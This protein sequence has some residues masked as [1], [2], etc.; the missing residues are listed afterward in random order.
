MPNLKYLFGAY[1]AMP[2]LPVMYLQGKRVKE[3]VPKLPEALGASGTVE[4]QLP[5]FR[6]VTIGESTIAGV[7]VETH[8]EGFTGTLAKR[9]AA[10]LNT[11]LEWKV[12]AKSGYTVKAMRHKLVPKVEEAHIDLIVIGAGAND[13]F[14]LSS[15]WK[16][17]K[18]VNALITELRKK[19]GHTP[20]VFTNMPPIKSFPAFTPLMKFFLG[21][22][23]D[24]LGEVLA[25]EV[26]KHDN[27][28]FYNRKITLEDWIERLDI[29][30]APEDFFSDGVHPSK[31]TYQTW[32]KDLVTFMTDNQMLRHVLEQKAKS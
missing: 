30:A 22:L 1:L 27:V 12:Y 5:F 21:N 8:E 4:G 29:T 25:A 19:Y 11:A 31:L 28:F 9:L 23:V 13:A 18:D 15:P 14:Q 24:I 16:W 7:G 20:I 26:R 17:K 3:S 32:A 2:I 10:Q 6:L